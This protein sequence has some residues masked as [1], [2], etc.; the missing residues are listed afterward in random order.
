MRFIT[1]KTEEKI[2]S[3]QL[4]ESELRFMVSAGFGLLQNIPENS[5][6]TYVDFSKEEILEFSTKIRLIMD[7]NGMSV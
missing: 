7:K 2:V 4:N 5:L 1:E 6:S 3:V